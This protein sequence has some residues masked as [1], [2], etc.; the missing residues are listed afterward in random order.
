L[1]PVKTGAEER[2]QLKQQLELQGISF[3]Y[4]NVER[5]SVDGLNLTVRANNK[6]GIVG[7]TGAGKT[8]LVD[9]ILGLLSPDKGTILVDGQALSRENLQ[10]WRRSLGYVPQTIYLTDASIAEDIAFGI[11]PNDIDMDAVE[12]AARIAALH[13]F[14]EQE[15]PS[16]YKTIVGE[17][18]V[19]L[20]GGQRQRIGIARAL[21][22]D[23][24]LLI[25]DEATSALDN[26]TERAIMDAVQ[27]IGDEK[28]IIMIA[29]RL[30]TVRACDKIVLLQHGKIAAS[31]TYDELVDQ[32]E[33]FRRMAGE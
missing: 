2:L 22:H 13:D 16:G 20:S 33:T 5:S 8:T 31:G 6:V 11:P 30:T 24:D 7:G 14:V 29:H 28:T 25:M 1:R 4:P 12:R 10:A 19:R 23:P 9:I 3:A 18:G 26:L 15:L 21:Y 17:R 27:N 32:N